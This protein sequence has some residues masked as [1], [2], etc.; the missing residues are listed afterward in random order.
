MG[1][2]WRS[3][4]SF[5]LKNSSRIVHQHSADM[6]VGYAFLLQGWDHVM[7]DVQV[8]PAGQHLGQRPLRQPMV[9]AG[10]IM[11]KNHLAGM[12]A[13]AHFG[14]GVD[15]IFEGEDGVDAEA[16]HADVRPV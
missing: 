4:R 12:T 16:V 1:G 2:S 5:S 15:T 11:G 3:V 8:V 7:V 14:H 9:V 6:L 13:L 10:S